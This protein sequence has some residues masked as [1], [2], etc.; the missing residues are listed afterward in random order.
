MAIPQAMTTTVR[1]AARAVKALLAAAITAGVLGGIPWGLLH[2]AGDPMP[3]SIPHLDAVKHALNSTMTPQVLLKCLSVVGWYLWLILAVSFAVELVAAARRVNAPHIPTLGPTQTLAA[4]LITA[5]GITALLRTVPAQATENSITPTGARV[6]ATAPSVAGTTS[7]YAAHAALDTT[8][9]ATTP[10]ESVHTVKPGES[11][12]SIAKEDLGDGN[13]WPQLYKL[14]AGVAQADGDKL[15]NPDLIRPDWKIRIPAPATASTEAPARP[16]PELPAPATAAP[17]TLPTPVTTSGPSTLAAP[18]AP[19]IAAPTPVTHTTPSNDDHGQG[20]RAKR[21]GGPAVSLPDGGTIGITLAVALGA[22]LVLARRWRTR[23]NDPRLPVA[24]PP[25]PGALLAARRAERALT[26]ATHPAASYG[27]VR[28]GELNDDVIDTHGIEDLDDDLFV[29]DDQEPVEGVDDWEDTEELDEFGAPTG[30]VLEPTATRFSAP[31][32][33]GSISAAERDGVELPLT[34]TGTGLGLVG[35]GA[36]GAARAIAASVLSAGAPDRTADLARLLIPAADLAALLGVD[37]TELPAITRGLPELFAAKDLAA[38]I[39]EAEI[40]ALLRTRLLEEYEQRDLDVL[41]A[42]HPDVE[43]C[44]PLVLMASPARSL[45]AQI[46][47][48]MRTSAHLRITTVLLG[49]HPDGP[50]AFVEA[51]GTATGP[52]VGNWSG[53]RLWNL[54]ATALADVLDLLARAAGHDPSAGGGQPELEDWPETLPGPDTAKT[55]ADGRDQEA[56]VTVLPVRALPEH[57]TPP[58]GQDPDQ[59]E[60]QTDI[61]SRTASGHATALAPVTVLPVRHAP[62]PVVAG[63]G[64]AGSGA[65]VRTQATLTAWETNP[66]RITVLGGLSITA[67]GQPV[68][69]LRTA[70]RVLAALLAVKGTAG[71]SAEQIDAMCWP[72]AEPE[73][74][75]RVAKWRADGLNSLRKRL[76]AAIGQRSPRL[77]LLDRATGRYRLN[78]ELIATDT[79]TLAELVAAA[80]GAGDTGQRLALLAAAEPLCRG[81]LLDGELGDNLDWASDYTATWADEQVAI[82]ARLATLASAAGR[83]D[84]ALT[85]L[86]KAAALTEDNEALYR[87]MFDILAD[88]GRHSEIPGKLRTLE[89]YADS[90]G[91]GVSSATREAAAREMKRQ[92]QQGVRQRH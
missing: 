90:L 48:L 33:P 41:A 64:T 29:V 80:R 18:A 77:V 7:L 38:A 8:T 54:S 81:Q 30:P 9:T 83:H 52:T 56:T 16:A 53:A 25:L 10:R 66:V 37:E 91:A 68:S 13:D 27:D 1:G 86:E 67:A 74:M 45:S 26:A 89:A 34:P 23:R 65:K 61:E 20:D 75:D 88:A 24:E 60:K 5:I 39:G 58:P 51:D 84:Q 78:P 21:H 71:A 40:H 35:P 82:L 59:A 6:A 69:G 44:P 62:E 55:A 3:H 14:N 4:A 12:Y 28:D 47:T 15:T 22:A 2:Y 43:D 42:A 76:A 32:S 87:Q 85:A 36:A 92:P 72:D 11:L 57:E 46:G 49:A 50:T 63:A 79:G 17:S 31:L 70:A 73:E 19:H